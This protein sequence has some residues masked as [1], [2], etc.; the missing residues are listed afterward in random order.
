MLSFDRVCDP[1]SMFQ[2]TFSLSEFILGPF[3]EDC[4]DDNIGEMMKTEQEI[5]NEVIM[6]DAECQVNI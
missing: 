3:E 2:D 1:V 4:S 5:K 6:N